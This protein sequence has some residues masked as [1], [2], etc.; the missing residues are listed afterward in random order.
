MSHNYV[1]ICILPLHLILNQ[2]QSLRNSLDCT[3]YRASPFPPPIVY[4]ASTDLG[5]GW[6]HQ[7][8]LDWASGVSGSLGPEST[9]FGASVPGP[10]ATVATA[11][12][13]HCPSLLLCFSRR[14]NLVPVHIFSAIGLLVGCSSGLGSIFMGDF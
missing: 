11:S 13:G 5:T 6:K 3:W 7:V 2:V 10:V 14:G 12:G 8:F 4:G 1:H 9:A